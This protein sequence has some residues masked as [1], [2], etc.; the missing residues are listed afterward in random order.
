MGRCV[1]HPTQPAPV[2][3]DVG[4]LLQRNRMLHHLHWFSIRCAAPALCPAALQVADQWR[5]PFLQAPAAGE[6]ADIV[7]IGILAPKR[8]PVGGTVHAGP[9]PSFPVRDGILCGGQALARLALTSRRLP[10]FEAA[11]WPVFTP[12]AT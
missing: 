6:L 2:S 4:D 11:P 8:G 12:P 9:P 5:K 10:D 7:T 3:V 1:L